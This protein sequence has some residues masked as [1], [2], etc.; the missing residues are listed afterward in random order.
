MLEN[1]RMGFGS[2]LVSLLVAVVAIM[3]A[4]YVYDRKSNDQLREEF[5]YNLN[6]W[7]EKGNYFYY[8]GQH[9]VFYVQDFLNDDD[10]QNNESN[11]K[12][13]DEDIH[14]LFLH[15]FPTNS[16]D[17]TRLWSLFKLEDNER[18]KIKAKSLITFDFMGYGFSDKPFDYDYSL[19]DMADIV[20]SLLI[21]LS[22]FYFKQIYI[23]IHVDFSVN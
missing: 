20:D 5:S 3:A 17:Y 2:K 18:A 12:N 10:D 6:K 7:Y 9:R 22:N 16:Y 15:G 23:E 14:V 4:L 1:I 21:H 8:E 13:N 11:N 19:F